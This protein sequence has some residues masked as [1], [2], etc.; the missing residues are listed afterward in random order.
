MIY[1]NSKRNNWVN[2]SKKEKIKKLKLCKATE[3][4]NIKRRQK[5]WVD[6]SECNEH[7]SNENNPFH[8][9]LNGWL[10]LQRV[11]ISH[12]TVI[13]IILLLNVFT[14]IYVLYRCCFVSFV[15][16]LFS[17][18]IAKW[19]HFERKPRVNISSPLINLTIF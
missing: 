2:R 17:T 10:C 14:T 18:R 7:I 1:F 9:Y 15:R 6:L 4:T 11:P 16:V 8:S 13:S 3:Q 5:K 19:H 12:I